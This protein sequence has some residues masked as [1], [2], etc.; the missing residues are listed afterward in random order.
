MSLPSIPHPPTDVKF[1]PKQYGRLA[2][3][4]RHIRW[5]IR[6]EPPGLEILQRVD[7]QLTNVM[8]D[9][10]VKELQDRLTHSEEE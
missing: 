7:V 8:I 2:A 4:R 9:I 5:L 1:S 6:Q 3:A 10:R